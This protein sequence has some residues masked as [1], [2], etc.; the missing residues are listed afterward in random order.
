MLTSLWWVPKQLYGLDICGAKQPSGGSLRLGWLLNLGPNMTTPNQLR[1]L[2]VD[3]CSTCWCLLHPDL[4]E[5][6]ISPGCLHHRPQHSPQSC[7]NSLLY[8]EKIPT[9]ILVTQDKKRSRVSAQFKIFISHKCWHRHLQISLCVYRFVSMFQIL[10]HLKTRMPSK[11]YFLHICRF[12]SATYWQSSG[13]V[14]QW[15]ST[16][17]FCQTSFHTVKL[18]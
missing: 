15:L 3:W 13:C 5:D 11:R 18:Q 16:Q 12:L 17:A 2:D 4:H 6:E 8:K 9:H 1:S 14:R 10:I 7:N